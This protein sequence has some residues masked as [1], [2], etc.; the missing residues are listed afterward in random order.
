MDVQ[1]PVSFDST[2]D[3]IVLAHPSTRVR[4]NIRS[5]DRDSQMS[6]GRHGETARIWP[7]VFIW[8]SHTP[9]E[10]P[11]DRERVA[12]GR[13]RRNSAVRQRQKLV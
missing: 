7:V 9:I 5:I 8:L 13:R 3:D 11:A 4:P 10:L 1:T 6:S 12:L 2:R